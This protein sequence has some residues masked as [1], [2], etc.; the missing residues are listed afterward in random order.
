MAGGGD[1]KINPMTITGG[2]VTG[3]TKVTDIETFLKFITWSRPT[4]VGH[5]VSIKNKHGVQ[6]AKRYCDTA[7]V[8]IDIPIFTLVDGI[9][10]DDLD[11]GELY[12]YIR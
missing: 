11:S 2:A 10:C 4:T 5:L 1:E 7:N 12:F 9:Y 3:S 6:L 8:D